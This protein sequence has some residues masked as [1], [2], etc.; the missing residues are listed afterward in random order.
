MGIEEEVLVGMKDNWPILEA[1]QSETETSKQSFSS[2]VGH[3]GVVPFLFG[4]GIQC[5]A[6]SMKFLL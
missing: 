1:E 3:H 6:C 2:H 5:V 4:A